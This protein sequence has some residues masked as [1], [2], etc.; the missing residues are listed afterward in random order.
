MRS[1]HSGVK[2]KPLNFNWV[3]ISQSLKSSSFLEKKV[4]PSKKGEN[5]SE[6]KSNLEKYIFTELLAG[7]SEGRIVSNIRI[8]L[9]FSR[10]WFNSLGIKSFRN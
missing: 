3:T 10:R 2:C 5:T 6:M 8:R 4:N 1:R 9:S 7:P